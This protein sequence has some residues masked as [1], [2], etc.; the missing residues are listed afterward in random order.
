MKV[1]ILYPRSKTHIMLGPDFLEGLKTFLQKEGLIESI[2]IVTESIG[3]G[4]EE[5]DVYVK[6]EKLLIEAEADLLVAF[7]DLKVIGILE[8]LLFTCNKL[9]LIVSPGANYP[10]QWSSSPHILHLTLLQAYMCWLTGQLVSAND[11]KDA[12]VATSF[13]DCGYLHVAAMA[14]GLVRA[15]GSVRYNYINNQKYDDQ[16]HIDE[17]AS[18]LQ[19]NKDVDNVMC[20]LD[21]VPASLFYKRLESDA[22]IAALNL[23]VSP[24]MLESQARVTL[25]EHRNFS[26]NGYSTWLGDGSNDNGTGFINSFKEKTKRPASV[27]GLLGWETGLLLKEFFRSNPDSWSDITLMRDSLLKKTITS[28]RGPLH[29]DESTGYFISP[30][31]RIQI[32]ADT[33]QPS[34]AIIEKNEDEWKEFSSV[35]ISGVTSGWLNTYLCY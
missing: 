17:L 1:G 2:S 29:L 13:Y 31:L 33:G 26:I 11:Q 3:F 28:P 4:G 14:R 18:F 22:E 9:A 21:S 19:Q 30:A 12:A 7:L 5:K 10:A 16:F 35:P 24:M 6:A 23:Y 25:G 34:V 27:F 32:A 20:V 8:P 15:G